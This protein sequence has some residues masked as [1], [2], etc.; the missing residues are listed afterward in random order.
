MSL[1][2]ISEQVV[3]FARPFFTPG[4]S[5]VVAVS[6][7]SDSVALLFLLHELRGRLGIDRLVIAH[8]NHGLR[9]GES[10]GDEQLVRHH[11]ETLGLE[12]YCRR[13][14]GHSSGETGLEAWAREERYRFFDELRRS[15]GCDL[16]ATGHTQDDQAETVLMRIVRGTG[17]N[18]LRGIAPIRDDGVVRPLL[19]VRKPELECWLAD[20]GIAFRVDRSNTD[21]RL[22]R[23]RIRHS[24]LP[25]LE[26]VQPDTVQH[27]ASL[28]DEAREQ[29][30]VRQE[31]VS[32]WIDRSLFA[33]TNTSFRLKTDGFSDRNA[34][35]ALRRILAAR[36]L[37]PTRHHITTLLA[38]AGRTGG[39]FL[40]P[41]GWHYRCGR[42][43]LYFSR[44]SPDFRFDVQIPG[45]LYSP[46]EGR[47]IRVDRIKAVPER[48]DL[49]KWIVVVDGTVT[50]NE[51]IYRTISP[52][53]TFIPFGT[54]RE[55]NVLKF[56]SKQ[57]VV[58]SLRER[59]GILTTI[60]NKPVWVHGIRLDER[61]RVTDATKSLIKIQSGSIL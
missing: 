57:G 61:F 48:L 39:I 60:D 22:L 56:L 3:H 10:D 16:I 2:I 26:P 40:L 5:V 35:E 1:K 4:V 6:G 25:Q 21:Q 38:T 28:A 15:T 20:N 7:G 14:E 58:R 50:G 18:G 12:C 52:E 34:S 23:N 36:A 9:G 27:L 17:L 54:D 31:E 37:H 13:L 43:V 29:W 8:V 33:V 45:E 41:E 11:A 49:G 53:D 44:S 47:T 30:N 51:F 46:E 32:A 55:V 42:G 24:V 59:T 19:Q